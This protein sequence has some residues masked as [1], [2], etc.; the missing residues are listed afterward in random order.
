MPSHLVGPLSH[1]Y[2]AAGF[3]PKWNLA[4]QAS[5]SLAKPKDDQ[6]SV[7]SQTKYWLIEEPEV[8]VFAEEPAALLARPQLA[9]RRLNGQFLRCLQTLNLRNNFL[10]W[11]AKSKEPRQTSASPLELVGVGVGGG[12]HSD[13]EESSATKQRDE[14]DSI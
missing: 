1:S 7:Y 8:E 4:S 6:E 10:Y 2:A 14:S 11:D 9:L 3:F 12:E 13:E 5:K